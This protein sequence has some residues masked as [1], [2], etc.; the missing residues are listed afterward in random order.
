MQ[1]DN[2]KVGAS[3]NVTLIGSNNVVANGV[4][5]VTAI[6]VSNL[7]IT[8]SNTTINGDGG[9]QVATLEL[10][11]AQIL[12]LNTTP[13]PFGITV[14]VGYYAQLLSAQMKGTYGGTPYATNLTLE[15]G[16]PSVK[17]IFSENVLGFNANVFF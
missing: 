11:S 4:E 17:A 9:V 13:V 7:N 1:G 5:N 12:A 3:K 14:P 6:G 8:Q 16:F 2:N 15:I 10:T